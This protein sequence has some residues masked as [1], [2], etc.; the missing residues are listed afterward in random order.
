MTTIKYNFVL[1]EHYQIY[2]YFDDKFVLG[3]FG[4][5]HVLSRPAVSFGISWL[6]GNEN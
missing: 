4:G 1:F 6:T 2:W 3:A 5:L